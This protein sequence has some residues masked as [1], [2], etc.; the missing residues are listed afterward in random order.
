MTYADPAF[1]RTIGL[2]VLQG[3]FIDATDTKASEPVVVVNKALARLY[4]PGRGPV[5]DC[6]RIGARSQP[7]RRIVARDERPLGSD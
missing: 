5:G 7:C 6:I 1:A 4:W 2:R 3:R